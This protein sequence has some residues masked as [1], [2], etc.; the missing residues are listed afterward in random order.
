[1]LD[2]AIEAHLRENPPPAVWSL[3]ATAFGDMVAPANGE[4][5][6][7]A[8]IEILSLAGVSA[9]AARTAMSRLVRDGW[10]MTRRAG[11]LAFHRMTPRAAADTAAASALIYRAAV[12]RWDGTV[13]LRLVPGPA[14]PSGPDGSRR[15]PFP[16]E[17]LVAFAGL[18]EAEAGAAISADIPAMPRAEAARLAAACL[19][20]AAVERRVAAFA[21]GHAGLVAACRTG[22][23]DGGRAIA[24]RL[25]LVHGFRRLA[26]RLPDLPD[27]LLPAD[28]AWPALRATVGEAYRALVPASA[29]WL[30]E[31]GIADG[32]AG[33]FA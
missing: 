27:E 7:A 9:T 31:R 24:A 23:A 30:A 4:I 10:L 1:L 33:R 21:A 12:P 26:L 15:L 2:A 17:V 3:T 28:S 20:L 6:T 19:D 18:P 29:R 22:A 25:L 5:A 13:R 11:R 16:G 14:R 8:L 32:T